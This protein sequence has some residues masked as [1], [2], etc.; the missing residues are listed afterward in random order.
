MADKEK[1]WKISSNLSR[2]RQKVS[3][4]L[5]VLYFV[6][7]MFGGASNIAFA[8]GESFDLNLEAAPAKS[9]LVKLSRITGISVLYDFNAVGPVR[10]NPVKGQYNIADA[11]KIMFDGTGLSGGLTEGGAIQVSLSASLTPR[12]ETHMSNME[13]ISKPT[14]LAGILAF[15]ISNTSADKAQAADADKEANTEGVWE[16]LIVTARKRAESLQDVPVSIVAFSGEEIE[17]NQ[18]F[19]LG[20]IEL[21][22]PSFN[23]DQIGL[24]SRPALRG[25]GG[26]PLSPG[27]DFTTGIFVDGIYQSTGGMTVVDVFDV[28]RIEVLRGPQGTLWGKNVIG[29][30]INIVPNK[31][32]DDFEAKIGLKVG[33]YGRRDLEGMVNFVTGNFKHRLVAVKRDNNGITENANTDTRI[34]DINRF[35]FRYS[36]AA[37]ITESISWDFT[38]DGTNDDQRGRNAVITGGRTTT[39]APSPHWDYMANIYGYNERGDNFTVFGADDGF[40]K[41]DMFG[42]RNEINIDFD[43]F[44]LTS[45]FAY[46]EITDGWYDDFTPYNRTQY[47]DALL[48]LQARG[49]LDTDSRIRSFAIGDDTE[50]NQWSKEIRLSNAG[51]SDEN[52]TWTIG[53]FYSKEKGEQ[54][55]GFQL[56]NFTTPAD[57]SGCQETIG[58]V[59][60][61]ESPIF[62]NS[63]NTSTDYAFFGDFTWHVSERFDVTAGLRYSH[64]E[65][66]FH[67]DNIGSVAAQ[68]NVDRVG[69]WDDVTYRLVLDYKVND[70]MLVYASYATGFKPGGATVLGATPATAGLFINEET[71]E[72]YELGFKGDLFDNKTRLNLALFYTDFV[73]LQAVQFNGSVGFFA[74]A[75]SVEVKGIELEWLQAITE[76][77]SSQIRYTFLDS[78]VTGFP[79]GFDGQALQRAP[80]HDVVGTLQYAKKFSDDSE[81]DMT[82]TASYRSE[83]FDDPD[84]NIV[85]RRPPRTLVDAQASYLTGDSKYRLQV[86]G[87][88]L[89]NED[90]PFMIADFDGG[91]SEILGEPRTF[92]ITLTAYF[93]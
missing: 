84:A 46:R 54:S 34:N 26:D 50:A 33:N 27:Q 65:K 74:N 40:A 44:T 60:V 68:Y 55:F 5:I 82:I 16:E 45:I 61:T 43:T 62:W 15:L 81:I 6:I 53:A 72:S 24:K 39:G 78:S 19:D 18:I 28:N 41:R 7:S 77:I 66:D 29:G 14:G 64:N 79:G 91:V 2:T 57:L 23:Y 83:S 12:E 47:A 70:D 93:Q 17:K 49:D 71:A 21:N 31:P 73:G 36:I 63:E 4:V 88:N 42:V 59:C 56:D 37:D 20:S 22:T 30:G 90:Y 35:S 85:E 75:D 80:R 58:I 76:N 13:K 38:L 52:V 67:G 9:S 89:F 8:S 86:W 10:T 1:G 92:G 87:K 48:A 25:F 51:Q 3:Y 11:L 69:T 32:V